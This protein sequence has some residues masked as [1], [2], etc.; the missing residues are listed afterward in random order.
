[1]AL[2]ISNARLRK[3]Y[4]AGYAPPNED[5]VG[6][7]GIRLLAITKC[8]VSRRFTQIEESAGN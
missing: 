2:N 4:G 7:F 6:N 3:S 1:M 8:D 5:E